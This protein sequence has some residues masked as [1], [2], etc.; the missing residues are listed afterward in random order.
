MTMQNLPP[1]PDKAAADDGRPLI[2]R[3]GKRLRST[4][5]RISTSQSMI[6][7]EPV[8]QPDFFDWTARLADNWQAIAQEAAAILRHRDA[9]PPLKEICPVPVPDCTITAPLLSD[10]C[11]VPVPLDSST[12]APIS[13]PV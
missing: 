13:R 3:V 12:L 6:P 2:I 4:V 11:P 5:D 7:T 9:V 1:L 8:L 10:I